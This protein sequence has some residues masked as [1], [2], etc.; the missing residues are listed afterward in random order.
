[1]ANDLAP[2]GEPPFLA[3]FGDRVR[4][5]GRR[6]FHL[7]VELHGERDGVTIAHDMIE[8]FIPAC[9]MKQLRLVARATR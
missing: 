9:E 8:R 1:M 2:I 3:R 6:E 4:I 5:L 7:V